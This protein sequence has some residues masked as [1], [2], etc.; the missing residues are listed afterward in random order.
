MILLAKSV[1]H[2][3]RSHAAGRRA[4]MKWLQHLFFFSYNIVLMKNLYRKIE[5]K[6]IYVAAF[7][8]RSHKVL[9]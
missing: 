3:V 8:D 5:V 6:F 7:P 1:V 9:H 4:L 2:L